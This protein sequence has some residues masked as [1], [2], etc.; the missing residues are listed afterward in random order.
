MLII[1]PQFLTTGGADHYDHISIRIMLMMVIKM[2]MMFII[3]D[4]CDDDG[5][6]N[7]DDGDNLRQR[8]AM[9]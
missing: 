8:L 4:D 2:I 5:N 1:M 6:A 7:G 3:Y 9:L